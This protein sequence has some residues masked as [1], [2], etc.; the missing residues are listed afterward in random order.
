MLYL[1]W[2]ADM[3]GL[4]CK[5]LILLLALTPIATLLYAQEKKI[6]DKE[7]VI[8]YKEFLEQEKDLSAIHADLYRHENSEDKKTSKFWDFINKKAYAATISEE[9]E[10][11]ILRKKWEDLLGLDIYYP[12]F[13]AK[14][15]EKKVSE[16]FSVKVFKLKGKPEYKNGQITYTFKTKF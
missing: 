4:I 10:R 13:K 2:E 9:E 15:V 1:N 3:R 8:F 11:K 12:Y 14:E 7:R 16:K 5:I 6:T